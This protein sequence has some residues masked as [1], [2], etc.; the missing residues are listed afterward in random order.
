MDLGD[1]GGG[2]GALLIKLLIICRLRR[3][4]VNELLWRNTTFI[5]QMPGNEAISNN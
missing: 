4:S 3:K 1:D 2:G 5:F